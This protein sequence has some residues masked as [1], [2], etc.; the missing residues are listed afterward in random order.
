MPADL[1]LI[2]GL[3][4]VAAIAVTIVLEIMTSKMIRERQRRRRR[5][6]QGAAD[7]GLSRGKG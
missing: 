6:E 7:P 2:A 5:L 1:N 4:C 3:I